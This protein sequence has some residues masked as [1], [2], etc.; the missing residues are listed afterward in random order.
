MAYKNIFK[1]KS[2]LV[3]GGAGSLGN[4]LVKTLLELDTQV[5]R[6][7]DIDETRLF[8]MENSFREPERL[9]FFIGSVRDK[10][11]LVRAAENVDFIFHLAALKHVMACE[12]DPFE[13]VKTNVLG[14]QNVIDA[15][16][17]NNV[18]KMIFTSSDKAANPN[19][20][21]GASK[22]L[23]EKLINSAN[24]YRGARRTVLA[25]VRFGNV[26]GTR[27]S[28]IPLFKDQIK[29]GKPLTITNPNMSRFMM[30]QR[31]AIRLILKCTALST[32]GGG[33]F[34]LKMPV[35]RVGDLAE[36]ILEESGSMDVK[37]EIIG[38]KPGETSFE[39][40]MSDDER[41]GA[42]EKEDMFIIPSFL[43]KFRAGIHQMADDS[44]LDRTGYDSRYCTPMPKEEL[45]ALLKKEGLV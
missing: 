35:V 4:Q 42:I 37:L 16:L 7:L 18:E 19:N 14:I 31:E 27:G 9:R 1:G 12:K 30:S 22:L 43:M 41:M 44:K 17:I 2:V 20:T 25:S 32:K 5:I 28:V 15:A 26:M 40:L 6:V 45:R 29:K 13:A 39:E 33:T 36:I 8:E 24:A 3:T 10:E 11:R 21:M 23:G 34:I 38:M